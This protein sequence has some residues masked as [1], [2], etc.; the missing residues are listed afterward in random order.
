MVT[1]HISDEGTD[2]NMIRN[3]GAVVK[4]GRLKGR[5]KTL[6]DCERFAAEEPRP[7][8]LK[9]IVERTMLDPNLSALA[10]QQIL[11]KVAENPLE[12]LNALNPGYSMQATIEIGDKKLVGDVDSMIEKAKAS[13]NNAS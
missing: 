10:T 2:Q 13:L 4:T 1:A 8:I 12:S 6:Q 5:Q 9:H 11:V 3:F 7:I